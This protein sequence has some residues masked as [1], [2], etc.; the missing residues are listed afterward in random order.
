MSPLSAEAAP[1]RLADH[2]HA[3]GRARLAAARELPDGSL[4]W[5][6]GYGV[7]FQPVPD[8]GLFNGRVGDALFLA[9][10]YAATGD[11]EMRDAALR[12]TAPLRARAAAPGG[13]QA[14][15][16][17]T[18]FGLTGVGSMVYALVRM[19][20]FLGEPGFVDDARA[21]AAVL[22]PGSVALDRK[23]EVFWG[24][25]GAVPGLLALAA[26]GGAEEDRWT[27]AAQAC[28]AH[29][30]DRRRPDPETGLRA[31]PVSGGKLETGFAHGSSG[32]A[33]ALLEVGRRTGEARF[34]EAALEAFAFER[35]LFRE[36]LMDWPDHRDQPD[37][38]VMTGWCHGAT[39]VGLSR[40][41][42]LGELREAE[43]GDVVADLFWALKRTT[44]RLVG[45][46]DN[47]CCGG[48]G[49]I[50][51]LLEAGR[52]LGNAS[53]ER[54][55]RAAAEKRAAA[56]AKHGWIVPEHGADGEHMKTGL[57]QGTSGI[58]YQLLRIDDPGRF[59]SVLLLA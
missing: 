7:T 2:A 47:L 55:A 28:A 11:P 10:L 49:R 34:R 38:R 50:D 42:A 56:A 14:L 18:G 33:H 35:A 8:A 32:I 26:E 12:A 22:T 4:T 51:F 31:W 20:G 5:H 53:L 37:E 54:Q 57:W 46:P 15:L 25:A 39:G 48:F 27:A 40:L 24:V 1:G 43:E 41:A 45:G 13:A 16:D 23:Y 3:V 6:P 21:L 58:G 19:A 30:L 17:E 29:L 44:Q 52:R 36:H 59:P 9:A